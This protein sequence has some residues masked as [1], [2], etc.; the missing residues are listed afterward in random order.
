MTFESPDELLRLRRAFADGADDFPLDGPPNGCPSAETIF[1][2]AHGD[3]TTMSEK[4]RGE[5][6]DHLAVCP[7]C[8]ETWRLAVAIGKEVAPGATTTQPAGLPGGARVIAARPPAPQSFVR[9]ALPVASALAALLLISL[10]LPMLMPGRP[11][12]PDT[13]MRGAE[14]LRIVDVSGPLDRARCV[15]R[16]RLEPEQPGAL[17]AVRVMDEQLELVASP[18]AL[19]AA[20]L[21]IPPHELTAIPPGGK[22]LWQ[23]EATFPDGSVKDSPTF[24]SPLP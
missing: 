4:D 14:G 23:V 11:G 5:L 19:A 12:G 10:A 18:S 7:V 24:E 21:A 9:R 3:L 17:F 6:L 1:A 2:A 13:A 20:E 8:G 15:L 16:W 22:L